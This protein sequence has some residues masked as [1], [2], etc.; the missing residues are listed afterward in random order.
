M[1]MIS[2]PLMIEYEIGWNHEE[3]NERQ[4]YAGL[5]PRCDFETGVRLK[6]KMKDIELSLGEGSCFLQF[7]SI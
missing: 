7:K 1:F 2:I 6:C 3:K 4:G 5:E